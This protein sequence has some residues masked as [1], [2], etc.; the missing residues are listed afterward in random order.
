MVLPHPTDGITTAHRLVI[1]LTLTMVQ[2]HLRDLRRQTPPRSNPLHPDGYEEGL[3]RYHRSTTKENE[4]VKLSPYPRVLSGE[5]GGPA[6][7]MPS[8]LPQD[9][10]TTW[11]KNG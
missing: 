7:S 2:L 3:R 6:L 11:R 5:P 10:K 1:L 9:G 4:E 8:S